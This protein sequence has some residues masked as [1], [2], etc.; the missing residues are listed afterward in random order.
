MLKLVS[1]V[2]YGL[3]FMFDLGD[4]KKCFVSSRIWDS[5]CSI[6]VKLSN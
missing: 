2:S 6:H 5:L 1:F 4:F 3:G